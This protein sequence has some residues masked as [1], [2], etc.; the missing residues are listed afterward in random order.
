MEHPLIAMG[1]KRERRIAGRWA[2]DGSHEGIRCWSIRPM[3]SVRWG[4]SS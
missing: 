2:D 4:R 1:R 3:P